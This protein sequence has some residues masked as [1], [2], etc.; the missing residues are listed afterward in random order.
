[1]A[2]RITRSL[3][4]QA[5]SADLG[6][7]PRARSWVQKFL[8]TGL[9]RTPATVAMYRKRRTWARPLPDTAAA[10]QGSAHAVNWRQYGIDGNLIALKLA[11][12][13]KAGQQ[14]TLQ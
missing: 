11:H 6:Y 13:G 10:V 9:L 7:F 12:F 4:M 1:M 14:R 2:L 8:M 3:R 5:V